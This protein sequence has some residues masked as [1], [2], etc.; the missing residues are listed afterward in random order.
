[1]NNAEAIALRGL[2]QFG[3]LQSIAGLEE[4]LHEGA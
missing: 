2:R 3:K 4:R 1:M